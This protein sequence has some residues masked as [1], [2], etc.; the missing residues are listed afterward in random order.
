MER[1]RREIALRQSEYNYRRL[2]ENLPHRFFL[3]NKDLVFISCSSNLAKDLGKPVEEV[4]GKTDADLFPAEFAEKFM[5]DDR[6]VMRGGVPDEREVTIT[7]DGEE[8]TSLVVKAPALNEQGE[9]DGVLGFY[10]DITEQ[11]QLEENYNRASKMESLGILAGGVAHDL[12]NILSVVVAYSEILL[13]DLPADDPMAAHIKKMKNSGFKASAIVADL[14]TIARGIAVT[15]APTMIN[16]LIL[17]YL[18]SSEFEELKSLYPDIRIEHQLA[19]DLLNI[20]ASSVHF[21]KVIMNLVSNAFES[22]KTAGKITLT[23]SNRH[24]D[25]S[26]QGFE[27]IDAGDYVVFSVHDDG[28]GVSNTDLKR[29]FEPFYTRKAMDRSGTGLGLTVVWNIVRDFKGGIDIISNQDG[30][31]FELFFPATRD[32][33]RDTASFPLAQYKGNGEKILVVDDMELQRETASALLDRLN[34]QTVTVS[35]GEEAIEYLGNHSVD[36]VLLDMVMEPGMNGHETYSKIAEIHPG[37]KAVIVSGYA[38]TADVKMAQKLGAGQYVKKPY[39]LESIGIAIQ[40]E[41]N[42]EQS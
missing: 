21:S 30:I 8:R 26:L 25:K 41:L 34:Y 42:P 19:D 17:D 9:V 20:H 5:E 38:E 1:E 24:L 32:A 22:V 39:S 18:Q 37:Q 23:T 35:S 2:I 33:V 13:A 4:V 12:N 11:K 14:L 40:Q 31:T 16:D 15:K 27:K 10:N 36:L 6:R 7:R 28:S 3:K 29:I